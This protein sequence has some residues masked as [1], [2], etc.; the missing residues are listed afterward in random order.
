MAVTRR[1]PEC[2]SIPQCRRGEH[3]DLSLPNFTINSRGRKGCIFR[4]PQYR[5]LLRT[6]CNRSQPYCRHRSCGRS[7][8][9][10]L[11]IADLPPNHNFCSSSIG[12][13]MHRCLGT[14]LPTAEALSRHP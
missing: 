14:A 3:T 8:H 5:L 6:H 2:G 12:F 11:T 9:S 10:R 4:Y 13:S 1:C 7:S